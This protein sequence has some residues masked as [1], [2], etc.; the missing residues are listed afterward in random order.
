MPSAYNS[1]RREI[2]DLGVDWITATA[3]GKKNYIRQTKTAERLIE[4]ER[5]RGNR[6]VRVTLEG[7]AGYSCGQIFAGALNGTMLMRLSGSLA[8]DNWKEIYDQS[9]NVSRLDLQAT[10]KYTPGVPTLYQRVERDVLK[11]LAQSKAR[12]DVGI[13]RNR[14]KGATC[15]IGSRRSDRYARIYDK[16]KESRDDSFTDC[17]RWELELKRKYAAAIA[18]HIVTSNDEQSAINSYIVKSFQGF[19]VSRMWPATQRLYN[20]IRGHPRTEVGRS[21]EWLAAGVSKRVAWLVAQGELDSVLHALGLEEH[22]TINEGRQEG[23]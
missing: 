2:V 18:K 3:A 20:S 23:E 8:Q 12:L 7:Y 5:D 16:H 6:P 11:K 10:V 15:E 19:G 1:A 17:W 13:R 14:L 4:Q 9:T 22:V 21:L